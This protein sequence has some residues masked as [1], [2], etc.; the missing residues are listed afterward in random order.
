MLEINKNNS[1][2]NND[3]LIINHNTNDD[4]DSN[5]NNNNNDSSTSTQPLGGGYNILAAFN[6][7]TLVGDS[8]TEASAGRKKWAQILADRTGATVRSFC[9]GGFTA[10]QWFGYFNIDEDKRDYLTN[11]FVEGSYPLNNDKNSPRTIGDLSSR[12]ADMIEEID[13]INND[14]TKKQYIDQGN[15]RN[16]P[17]NDSTIQHPFLCGNEPVPFADLTYTKFTPFSDPIKLDKDPNEEVKYNVKRPNQLAIIYL[18]T[19]DGLVR[20]RSNELAADNK[21]IAGVSDLPEGK[22]VLVDDQLY[23]YRQIIQ[24]FVDVGACVLLIRTHRATEIK[25]IPTYTNYAGKNYAVGNHNYP[26]E[27]YHTVEETNLAIASIVDEFI[28][29]RKRDGA[30]VDQATKNTNDA[31]FKK[32]GVQQHVVAWVDVPFLSGDEYH[33]KYLPKINDNRSTNGAGVDEGKGP[34]A[35]VNYDELEPDGTHYNAL[36]YAAFVDLLI[37]ATGD[38]SSDM[39]KRLIPH[40]GTFESTNRGW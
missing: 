33:F 17:N 23:F 18:G 22:E 21:C 19:N 2:T 10:K 16:D 32:E 24:D 39:K 8:L 27:H 35:E 7:I 30:I 12:Y 9:R 15:Y 36:G 37:R 34:L 14:S 4:S 1:N 25:D 6:N 11:L 31:Y 40:S 5:N 26:G 28:D 29:P 20:D 3:G 38:L 13:Q